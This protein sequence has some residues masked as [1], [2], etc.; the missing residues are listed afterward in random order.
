MRRGRA[1]AT[2]DEFRPYLDKSSRKLRHIFGR[3]HV[4][5][6]PL[7][8]TRQ[9]GVR[10]GGERFAGNRTHFFEGVEQVIRA[11]AAVEADDID[12]ETVQFFR[13]CLRRVAVDRFAVHLDRHLGDDRQIGQ[14]FDSE[15]CLFDEGQFRKCF[16]DKE[17]DDAFEQARDL[18]LVH[19]AGLVKRSRTERFKAQTQRPD[20]A[21]DKNLVARGFAGQLYGRDIYLAELAFQSIRLQL[22]PRRSERICLDNIGT[23]ADIFLMDLADELRGGDVQLVVAAIDID[24]FVVKPRAHGTVK[25]IDT[26][27]I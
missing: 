4:K 22:M 26:L 10:L 16:E 9:T 7:H 17:I 14:L 8:V 24:A 18:L 25:Y 12:A 27:G 20:R 19:L 6:P 5:L 2:A 21:R 1:A 13:K 11:H 23:G 3:A 15:D